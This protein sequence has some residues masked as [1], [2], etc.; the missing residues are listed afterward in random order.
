MRRASLLA[1]AMLLVPARAYCQ[2]NSSE[3]QTLQ[4][5]LAEVRALRQEL[6]TSIA[7]VQKAQ[8]LIAR[9]QVQEAVV[10]HAS[11]HLDELRSKLSEAQN[12]TKMVSANLQELQDRISTEDSQGNQK[13]LQDAVEQYKSNLQSATSDEQALQPAEIEAEQQLRAEQDKLDTLHAQ[14]DE[15]VK[16]LDNVGA[17]S[18]PR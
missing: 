7:K 10:E 3:S 4:Q 15:I 12:R 14:L 5:L 16:A 6:R 9:V 17:G 18:A 8:I 2:S 13:D 11:Q 1:L